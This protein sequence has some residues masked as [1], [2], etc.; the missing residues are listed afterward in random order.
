MRLRL[1]IESL[2]LLFAVFLIIPAVPSMDSAPVKFSAML[3][4]LGVFVLSRLSV[5]LRRSLPW[6]LL[7]MEVLG[8]GLAAWLV[9]ARSSINL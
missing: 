3:P 9:Q 6:P 7:I 5:C 1:I 2:G 8:F 4:A